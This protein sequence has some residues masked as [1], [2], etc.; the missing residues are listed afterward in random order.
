ML[1]DFP[2][3]RKRFSPSF[4]QLRTVFQSGNLPKSREIYSMVIFFNDNNLTLT[5][6]VFLSESILEIRNS[7]SQSMLI[8]CHFS[9][10]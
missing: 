3:K 6:I 4:N 2:N 7:I 8:L 9:Q 1:Y 10:I 5:N